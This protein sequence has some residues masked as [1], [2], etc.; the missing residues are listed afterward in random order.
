[1]KVEFYAD[2]QKKIIHHDLFSNCAEVLAKE[3]CKAWLNNKGDKLEKNKISQ[4]RKFYDEVL[5][6]SDFLKAGED[7]KAILPYVKM[8]NAK[9]AYAEGRKLITTEFKNFIKQ[10]L[11]HLTENNPQAFELFSSFFE[12]FMGYYKFEESKYKG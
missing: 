10:S 11:D 7:Y 5:R 9:A 3:I 4:I 12:A 6:F 2:P 1:M 8:L